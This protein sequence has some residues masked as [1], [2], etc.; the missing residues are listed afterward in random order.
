MNFEEFFEKALRPENWTEEHWLHTPTCE[1]QLKADGTLFLYDPAL[2][3]GFSPQAVQALTQ[4][5]V[6][7]VK[8]PP[9]DASSLEE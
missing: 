3:E 8:L 9:R 1:A 6:E 5:L 2:R 7:H 4:F